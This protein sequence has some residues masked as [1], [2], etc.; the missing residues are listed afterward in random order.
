MIA[1]KLLELLVILSIGFTI[2]GVAWL[3]T[4]LLVG[5][6][7]IFGSLII[8]FASLGAQCGK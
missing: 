4:D 7:L 3:A 6:S 1:Q 2:I 8:G 5:V